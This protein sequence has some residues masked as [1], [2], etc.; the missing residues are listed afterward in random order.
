MKINKKISVPSFSFL[1]S[2]SSLPGQKP[3]PRY[4]GLGNLKQ[5]YFFQ[6]YL[7]Q[8]QAF[9]TES[10]AG[11]QE[12]WYKKKKKKASFYFQVFIF[13]ISTFP[14]PKPSSQYR[15]LGWATG[16]LIQ[17]KKIQKNE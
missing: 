13:L 7:G 12:P 10:L 4:R 2:F 1:F 14:G 11:R 8:N 9:G 6:S 15:E 3:S 16:G 5:F 17:N